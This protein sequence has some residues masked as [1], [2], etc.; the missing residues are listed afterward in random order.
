M[1]LI[2]DLNSLRTPFAII[3]TTACSK[4]LNTLK[5]FLFDGVFREKA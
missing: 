5:E 3:N 1:A 4:E 2:L